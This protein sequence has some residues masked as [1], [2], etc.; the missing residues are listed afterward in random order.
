[1][2]RKNRTLSFRLT[3]GQYMRYRKM[4]GHLCGVLGWSDLILKGLE[5]LANKY[6]GDWSLPLMRGYD[7]ENGRPVGA[8]HRPLE[9]CVPP[10]RTPISTALVEPDKPDERPV[11]L[12]ERKV[13][14]RTTITY[15][16]SKKKK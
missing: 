13:D 1:M 7:P 16:L 15:H 8:A 12:L 5:E 2:F 9:V 14:Q 4:I 10:S 6:P 3:E 11:P